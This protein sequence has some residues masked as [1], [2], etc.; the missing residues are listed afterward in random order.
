MIF[1]YPFVIRS[2]KP[3]NVIDQGYYNGK[4]RKHTNGDIY[5]LVTYKPQN[6]KQYCSY[7]K[8]LSVLKKLQENPYIMNSL[9][10]EIDRIK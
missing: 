3:Q 2:K 9:N 7:N 8:A 4:K 6:A 10:F 5:M 1:S